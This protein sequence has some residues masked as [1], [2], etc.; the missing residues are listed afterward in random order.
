M[1]V[2]NAEQLKSVVNRENA[3]SNGTISNKNIQEAYTT[4]A[5]QAVEAEKA[6]TANNNTTKEQAAKVS[7]DGS[8]QSSDLG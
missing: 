5:K 7:I 4:Q 2:G 8:E 1:G 6:K 3:N